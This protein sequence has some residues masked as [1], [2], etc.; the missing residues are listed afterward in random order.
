MANDNLEKTQEI[1]YASAS[2][3]LSE[4]PRVQPIGVSVEL[5]QMHQD[6][7]KMEQKY[8]KSVESS[9]VVE[10]DK[11]L[12]IRID[13]FKN[14]PSLNNFVK[15][16]KRTNSPRIIVIQ[17]EDESLIKNNDSKYS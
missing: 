11:S 4:Q 8:R 14:K 10:P 15:K 2:A 7:N 17:T 5:N 12:S 3:Y 6:N 16:E 13:H 9:S 1:I